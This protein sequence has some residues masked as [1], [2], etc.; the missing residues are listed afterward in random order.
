MDLIV[1]LV[2]L[3]LWRPP[4]EDV[5]DSGGVFENSP[6]RTMMMPFFICRSIR[7]VASLIWTDDDDDDDDAVWPLEQHKEIQTRTFIGLVYVCIVVVVTLRI[8]YLYGSHC[9]M[10]GRRPRLFKFV[11]RLLWYDFGI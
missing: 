5:E 3:D 2:H 11:W 1:L 7:F 4:S 6:M 8:S 9:F 10:A